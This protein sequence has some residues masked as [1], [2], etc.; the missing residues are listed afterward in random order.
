VNAP[1][2]GTTN[3]GIRPVDIIEA[4]HMATFQRTLI[5]AYSEAS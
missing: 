3:E 1:K 2:L 4:A 5:S